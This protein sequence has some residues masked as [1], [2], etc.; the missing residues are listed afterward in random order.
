[1]AISRKNYKDPNFT[2]VQYA[3]F[4]DDFLLGLSGSKSTGLKI[5]KRLT[6]FLQ[7]NLQLQLDSEKTHLSHA[8]SDKTL[9]L[10][11]YIRVL[12]PKELPEVSSSLTRALARKRAQTMRVKQQLDDRWT[13]ECRNVVLKC[14]TVAFEKWRRELGKDG[15]KK[16]TFE[17]ATQQLLSMPEE[18]TLLWRERAQDVLHVFIS[19]ALRQGLFPQDEVDSYYKVLA[20]LEKSLAKVPQRN[21]EEDLDV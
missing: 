6:T 14:W 13:R 2:R 19:A 21:F 20:S 3:R 11:A 18:D 7:S 9:F 15:A 17:A 1:L 4:G 8:V 5:M 16:K 10:G 12:D